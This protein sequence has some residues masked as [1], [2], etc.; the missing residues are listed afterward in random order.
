M[1]LDCLGG[2]RNFLILRL[3][4]HK[5][6]YLYLKKIHQKHRVEFSELSFLGFYF[7]HINPLES[8]KRHTFIPSSYLT[9]YTDYFNI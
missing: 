4:V 7:L 3:K 6:P 1:F 9:V 5:D 2:T 8:L